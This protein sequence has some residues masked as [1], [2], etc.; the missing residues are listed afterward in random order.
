VSER[1]LSGRAIDEL[2]RQLYGG[3]VFHRPHTD[4]ER[5]ELDKLAATLGV[6]AEAQRSR[7]GRYAAR[8]AVAAA[9]RI[10]RQLLHPPSEEQ[11][12]GQDTWLVLKLLLGEDLDGEE[13][14]SEQGQFELSAEGGYRIVYDGVE[15]PTL[16]SEKLHRRWW[17]VVALQ[18]NGLSLQEA[19]KEASR[20]YKG[21]PWAGSPLTMWHAYVDV[22]RLRR[23]IKSKRERKARARP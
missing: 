19:Y 11:Q 10:R 6:I 20:I 21:T 8:S 13:R 14:R 23:A 18:Q 16:Q 9:E 12:L 7:G 5:K 2:C 22:Q 15:P 1:K 4:A 3:R 17:L